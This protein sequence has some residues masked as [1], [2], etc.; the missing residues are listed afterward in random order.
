M[1][2]NWILT[3]ESFDALLAWLDPSP[4]A[5]GRKYEVIRLRL[6]KI[7]TCRGCSEAEDLADESINRV[8]QKLQEIGPT[9]EGDPAPYFYGVAN[10]VYLE[11]LR[12]PRVQPPPPPAD[13]YEDVEQ[14][15]A[16][17]EKCIEN[18]SEQNRKLVREY[19][20]GEKTARIINRKQMADQLGIALNA[21]RI[22][23]HRLRATLLECVE[24]CLQSATT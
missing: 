11:H 6:I 8:S 15:Y 20:L 4:D 3:Q 10:K 22:R 19:Y 17:L 21:L 9:Y 18:L 7:F 12:R 13:D 5:A 23:A 1:K 14:E 16:C 2:K 24:G